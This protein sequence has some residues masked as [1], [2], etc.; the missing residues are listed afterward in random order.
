MCVMCSGYLFFFKKGRIESIWHG[1]MGTKGEKV[2]E[3]G[4]GRTHT[5]DPS[6]RCQE[7]LRCRCGAI[8]HTGVRQRQ[9][10]VSLPFVRLSTQIDP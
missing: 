4:R 3:G 7:D 1:H 5:G 8:N 9:R 6:L 2:A 10:S